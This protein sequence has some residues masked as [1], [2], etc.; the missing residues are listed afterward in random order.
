MLAFTV[1]T[2]VMAGYATQTHM[3]IPA[4]GDAGDTVL[5]P[6]GHGK[7]PIPDDPARC[8]LCQEYLLAGAYLIPAPVVLPMPVSVAFEVQR[9]VRV[10]PFVATA[11]HSWL[12]RAPPLI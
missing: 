4:G 6:A 12:G 10:L 5:G 8:P 1:L 11:S 9:L 2:F 7:A 3:H